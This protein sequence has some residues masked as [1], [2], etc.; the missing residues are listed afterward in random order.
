VQQ[1][2]L[3]MCSVFCFLAFVL[4]K[5]AMSGGKL[6]ASVLRLCTV[7][8]FLARGRGGVAAYIITGADKWT[9]DETASRRP[10]KR[11]LTV[12]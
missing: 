6:I 9:D 2:A 12:I 10:A 7:L 3:F 11:G 1:I 4:E 5:F 8:M